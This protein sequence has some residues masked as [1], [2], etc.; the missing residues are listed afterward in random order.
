MVQIQISYW[1]GSALF[2]KAGYIWAQQDWINK[3]LGQK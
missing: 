1:S 3:I 2:S